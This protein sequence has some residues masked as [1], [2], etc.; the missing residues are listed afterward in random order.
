MQYTFPGIFRS[1]ACFF[2][3]IQS[4]TVYRILDTQKQRN[5]HF[6]GFRYKLRR[7]IDGT[8]TRGFHLGKVALYQLSHYRIACTCISIRQTIRYVKQYFKFLQQ[9]FTALICSSDLSDDILSRDT[10]Y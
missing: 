6:M 7:A 3:L 2:A 10:L 4:T 9:I 1:I 8:R 5:P